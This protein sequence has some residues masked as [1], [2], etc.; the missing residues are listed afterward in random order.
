M[1]V[2]RVLPTLSLLVLLM[3]GC[4]SDQET[5]PATP[6]SCV[7]LDDDGAGV[8]PLV[9]SIRPARSVH[10]PGLESDQAVAVH[11]R[12]YVYGVGGPG[13]R[14]TRRKEGEDERRNEEK[15]LS[16]NESVDINLHLILYYLYQ[17]IDIG[18]DYIN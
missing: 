8:E 11:R 18:E 12:L 10:G 9:G 6:G 13:G 17:E 3:V 2:A 1:Y 16:K 5:S 15:K 14:A 4:A 7:D